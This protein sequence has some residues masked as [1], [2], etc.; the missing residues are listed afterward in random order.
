MKRKIFKYKFI[1]WL[2]LVLNIVIVIS[3]GFG[4][5]NRISEYSLNDIEEI[6]FTITTLSIFILSIVLLVLLILK[7]K[8]S[9]II[10]S[11]LFTLVMMT[12]S[13]GIFE[14]IFIVKDFGEDKTDYF[15]AFFL[16][17][18]V[19]GILFI[20]QRFKFKEKLYEIEIDSIGKH[21]D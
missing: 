15:L 20:I 21:T 13:I 4:T 16:Y 7:N 5:F 11:C 2:I 10:L 9:V 18:I 1:Y 17:L 6:L 8:K 3:F 12:F 19:F 14:S